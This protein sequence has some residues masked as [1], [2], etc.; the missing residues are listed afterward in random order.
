MVTGP[1]FIDFY[2]GIKSMLAL[3]VQWWHD[4]CSS[5]TVGNDRDLGLCLCFAVVSVPGSSADVLSNTPVVPPGSDPSVVPEFLSRH[6]L[7]V[8]DHAVGA[9][10]QSV[11]RVH[12]VH[13]F[14]LQVSESH[15]RGTTAD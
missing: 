7:F 15:S 11:H 4:L 14:L 9:S 12:V 10:C 6:D 3:R 13:Q 1:S 8:A 5:S 2:L